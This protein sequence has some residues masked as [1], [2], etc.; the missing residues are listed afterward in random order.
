MRVL[1]LWPALAMA[2]AIAGCATA[3]RDSEEN[4]VSDYL[5]ALAE[6]GAA[7]T[8]VEPGS[9]AEREAV[10]G[11]KALLSD[12]KAPDF[13]Q[14]VRQVYAERLY[15]NDTLKT[16]RDLDELAE[17]LGATGENLESG[18]VEFLDVVAD[19]GNYYFRWRMSL[20]FKRFDR[21]EVHHSLGMSHVRFD[22]D[23]RVVLHQDF[24][25]SAGGLFEHVPVL[26]WMIRRAKR[27][28]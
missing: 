18:T 12:F 17:Y 25:D 5:E 23:G 7:G 13:R 11:F 8:G 22:G 24:W 16:I 4:E 27:R 10:D 26:G 28:L 6:I 19:E 2:L 1:R 3:A 15:F 21:G 9:E 14:R 20:E